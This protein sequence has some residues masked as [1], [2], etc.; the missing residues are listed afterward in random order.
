[1]HHGDFP[2]PTHIN[3]RA[4]P[5]LFPILCVLASRRESLIRIDGAPNLRHKES[6]RIQLMSEGLQR[7]GT[8]TTELSDGR[9]IG[10]GDFQSGW[11]VTEGDHR[12]HMSFRVLNALMSG[13]TTD[14]AGS[15]QVS[16]PDFELHLG[17]LLSV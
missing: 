8:P 9:I 14:G 12:I 10:F 5:D 13:V 16:Y 15:E 2:T 6:D 17:R 7:L 11:V 3:V 1:M 4:C